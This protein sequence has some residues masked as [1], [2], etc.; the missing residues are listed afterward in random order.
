MSNPPIIWRRALETIERVPNPVLSRLRPPAGLASLPLPLVA[1]GLALAGQVGLGSRSLPWVGALLLAGGGLL[2]GLAALRAGPKPLPA[3][4]SLTSHDGSDAPDADSST[5]DTDATTPDSRT[6]LSRDGLVG[7]RVGLGALVLVTGV[8]AAF[9]LPW[10]GQVPSGL[11][12]D[13]ARIGLDAVDLLTVGWFS[14]TWSGWPIFHLVTVGYV[15]ALGQTP[16]A[17]RLPSALVGI[18]YAPALFLLGRQLGG[19]RLGLAAG[20]LGAVAFWHADTTRAA[21]GYGAWGLALETVAVALLLRAVRRP[22][23]GLT[24]LAA[25]AF[26]LALQVS[27]AALAALGAGLFLALSALA[28]DG[29]L[30][31][32]RLGVTFGP[33]LVY[34]AVAAGPVFIGMGLPD[35]P[36]GPAATTPYELPSPSQLVA[37]ALRLFL[38][39]NVAGDPSP[40]HNLRGEPMLDVVTAAL[41]VLGLG[42]AVARWRGGASL[43]ILAWLALALGVATVFGR[44]TQPDSLAALH[45]LTPA[46]LLAAGALAATA[47]GPQ[48]RHLAHTSLPLDLALLLVLV[49]VGING[50]ALFVRR[51]ADSATWTAYASAE[52]L[53]AREIDKLTATHEIY[54]ADAWF[55]HPTIRFLARGMTAPRRLDPA[56]TL[57]LRRDESF[58]YFAPGNQEV[59][60]E[61]LERLYEDGEIDRYRSPLDENVVAVR[62]FRAPARVVAEARGVTLRATSVERSRTNRYTLQAFRLD[63]PVSGES[64]RPSTLDLFAAVSVDDP[65]TYRLRLDAPAGSILEVNGVQVAGP[66]QDVPVTLAGGSQRIHVVAPVN[67]PTRVELRWAPPGASAL[68]P[69]P[70]DRLSREQRAAAGLLALYRSGTD[71]SAPIELARVERHLQRRESQP[72]LNRPYVV[73]WIGTVDAPKSGTYRFR[74]DANGPAS[75]WLDDQPVLIGVPPGSGAASV[76]LPD[77]DHRIQARLVDAEAPTRFDLFWAPPGEDFGAIPTSRFEPPDMA[78]DT[79]RPLAATLDPPLAPLGAPRVRW[80]ASTEGEPRAVTVRPDGTVFLTNNS[81]RQVQQVLDQGRAVVGL[82]AT[83]TLPAD[84]EAGPDGSIWAV[85]ALTGQIARLNP[86]GTIDLSIENRELGLYRPRGIALAPDGSI[87]VADTGGNRIVRVSPNGAL[88]W[89]VGP[90]V[91]GPERIRQPTDVAVGPEGQVFVVNGEAGAVVRLTAEGRYE[92]HWP[93]L[94]SNTERGAHLAIGPDRSVWVSEPEGRRVSRFTMDGTPSGV[95]DQTSAGRLLRV[96]VGIAVGPDGTLYVADASLRAVVA[97]GFGR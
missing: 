82:P 31:G 64:A 84:V 74:I 26:G 90:D 14:H 41:F 94:A 76:V 27:W 25:L 12:A 10:L 65:G 37:G 79:A 44:N 43:A 54:L 33:F 68:E 40:L 8:A 77:G 22:D 93:I 15:A 4:P 71:P 67:E 42:V 47:G 45:A 19:T 72:V 17:L 95:V 51:P 50:H 18:A 81:A 3:T 32:R 89:A 86:Q 28:A 6:D 48:A 20:L 49:I 11:A 61:D 60:A 83:F 62:S 87:F 16:L 85:D 7:G 92:R 57:P 21:W 73:D 91:G 35:R 2:I 56:T 75:L 23:T 1:L 30:S 36:L 59:V 55:D 66:A 34:F 97:L 9:R 5:S 38:M 29:T 52:T 53:A 80:L 13:E 46:L 58:A 70:A 88:L 63:W 39:F 24:V 69:I 78:V 96:P